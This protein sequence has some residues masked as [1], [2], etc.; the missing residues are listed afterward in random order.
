MEKRLKHYYFGHP[1]FFDN[2]VITQYFTVD[3]HGNRRF[4][5][6]HESLADHTTKDFPMSQESLK[7]A[8]A[9]IDRFCAAWES[10][11]A[12]GGAK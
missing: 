1:S 9:D 5:F 11:K 2:R 12:N 8:E 6:Q 10:S 7:L 4:Y 3:D